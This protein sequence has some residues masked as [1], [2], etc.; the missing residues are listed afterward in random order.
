MDDNTNSA[1]QSGDVCQFPLLVNHMAQRL[2]MDGGRG[3]SWVF[4]EVLD[5]LMTIVVLPVRQVLNQE[6]ITYPE[7]LVKNTCALL[8][9][10]VSELTAGVA[11][12]EVRVEE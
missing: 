6:R 7:I 12:A 2:G 8:T 5:K 10:I 4:K 9:A 1:A 3:S 11:G